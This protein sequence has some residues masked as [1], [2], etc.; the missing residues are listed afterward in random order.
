MITWSCA[1]CCRRQQDNPGDSQHFLCY[2]PADTAPST[3][4]TLGICEGSADRETGGELSPRGF[5]LTSSHWLHVL[6]NRFPLIH[7]HQASILARTLAWRRKE[8]QLLLECAES[9]IEGASGSRAMSP[10]AARCAAT[11]RILKRKLPCVRYDAC[12]D[13]ANG[14]S[15]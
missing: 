11:S 13:V 7:A 2:Q 12:L 5:L 8:K 1:P 10:R 3:L 9:A 4:S 6:S 14:C 15:D